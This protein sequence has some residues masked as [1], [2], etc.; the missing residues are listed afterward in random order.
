MLLSE[1]FETLGLDANDSSRFSLRLQM[2]IATRMG[3]FSR[4]D[5]QH[6]EGRAVFVEPELLRRTHSFSI[7]AFIPHPGTPIPRWHRAVLGA[8]RGLAE[9]GAR[10]IDAMET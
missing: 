6:G 10:L 9:G 3:K 8:A 7:D 5:T 2:D 4:E 1:A